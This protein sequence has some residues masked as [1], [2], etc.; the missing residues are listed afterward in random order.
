[1]N[2]SDTAE[3]T[4]LNKGPVMKMTTIPLPEPPATTE[5]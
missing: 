4:V 3:R 1:M 2:Q 5:L